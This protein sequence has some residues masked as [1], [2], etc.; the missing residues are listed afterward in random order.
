VRVAAGNADIG[1]AEQLPDHGQ[2]DALVQGDGGGRVPHGVHAVM[3]APDGLEDVR[4]LLPVGLRIDGAAVLLSEDN[5]VVELS[6]WSRI[7]KAGLE[8]SLLVAAEGGGQAAANS[9]VRSAWA[10][11]KSTRL[12]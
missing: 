6:V 7:R 11:A 4:P 3:R 9:I 8:H 2:G 12:V 10:G 1:V 5:A